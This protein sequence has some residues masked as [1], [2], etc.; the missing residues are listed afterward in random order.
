M[1]RAMTDR[2]ESTIRRAIAVLEERLSAMLDDPHALR[3]KIDLMRNRIQEMRG[4][5]KEREWSRP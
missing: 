3:A 1:K 5:L 4:Q 2:E